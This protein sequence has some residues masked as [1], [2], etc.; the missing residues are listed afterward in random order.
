MQK[1]D[2][3]LARIG[4]RSGATLIACWCLGS[5]V[6]VRAGVRIPEVL[7]DHMVVQQNADVTLWGWANVGRSVEVETSW[8][9]KAAANVEADGSWKLKVR[10]PAAHPLSE[11][12]HPET[13]T[14]TMPEENVIQLTDVLVGEVWLCSGQSNMEM[15]L[16]PGYPPGWNGWDGEAF[17]KDEESKKSD[18]PYLRVFDV[19]KT[20]ANV[21]QDDVKGFLPAKGIQPKDAQGFIRGRQRG[22]QPST[23]STAEYFSAVA[24]YF[25]SA[26]A[27]NLQVPVGLITSDVGG[28]PI[29][30]FMRGGDFYNGMI[31]PLFPMTLRGV[32]WYQGESNVGGPAGAY[33]ALFK[34]MIVDWRRRF[35][36]EAMPFYYVQIAPYGTD[37]AEAQ[38]REDQASVLSLDHTGMAV[39]GDIS[40]PT[41]IHPKNKRDV[42]WRL[43]RQALRKTYGRTEVVADGPVFDSVEALD[44]K[45]R[46]KFSHAGDGLV[47][48]DGKPIRCF[49]VAG[50]DGNFVPAD[51][52]IVDGSVVVV[53]ST[54][55]PHPS[56]LRFGWGPSDQ[57]NLG[58]KT[59]LPVA[60]FRSVVPSR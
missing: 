21:P 14:L 13:I 9:E 2:R 22:W 16:R 6:A 31:N 26:L 43:A 52:G 40:D 35:G 11:G 24:Y 55:V 19:E 25:G 44:G 48:C 32:I 36:D 59:G 42:G 53:S 46:V 5:A 20:S 56:E 23:A 37:P 15:M 3:L 29:Q 38:L 50:P 49:A 8:G 4:R 18:R 41:H 28:M 7:G 10:T 27:D 39:I 58:S 33:A 30:S 60:Q 34:G 1:D 57:P 17:W 54:V 45:L 12:L 47:S 51:A